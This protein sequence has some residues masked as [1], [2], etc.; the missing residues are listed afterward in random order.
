MTEQEERIARLD[1]LMRR[2]E[3]YYRDKFGVGPLIN[4]P[5]ENPDNKGEDIFKPLAYATVG[6]VRAHRDLMAVRDKIECITA[7]LL[8]D[9]VNGQ[10]NDLR[11]L[12]AW[13]ANEAITAAV[14]ASFR[15]KAR[16]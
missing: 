3:F 12:E 15:D 9:H 14:S 2:H 11:F 16:R 1:V 13:E 8:A 10:P 4:I 6:D 5:G 7:C